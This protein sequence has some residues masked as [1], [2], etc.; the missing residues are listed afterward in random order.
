MNLLI[1]L[2]VSVAYF[3]SVAELAISAGKRMSGHAVSTAS[4]TYFDSVV[5][6]TMFLLIG[7]FIE[8]FSKRHAASA[9]SSLNKLQT[10][11]A[12]LVST[13]SKVTSMSSSETSS[14]KT[15]SPSLPSDVQKIPTDLL[16]VGD[17]VRLPPGGTPPADGTIVSSEPTQFDESSL[18]GESRNVKK[19][20]GDQVYVG[21]INK[22][23]VVD[24]RVDAIGGETM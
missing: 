4:M 6:L 22:L 8:A 10:T 24:V 23:R 3:S 5:F 17:I 9:I 7:R 2:G 20:C 15:L 13:D 18:T 12:L 19:G 11:E 16:E 14:E 21:T 1:S